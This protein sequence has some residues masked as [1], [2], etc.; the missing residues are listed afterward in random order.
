MGVAP[1]PQQRKPEPQEANTHQA[2]AYNAPTGEADKGNN[3]NMCD[4]T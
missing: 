4:A 1:Y 2:P 3:A